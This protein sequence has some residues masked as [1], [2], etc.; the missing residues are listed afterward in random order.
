M[1]DVLFAVDESQNLS[2]AFV[3]LSYLQ[4]LLLA[5]NFTMY[6]M[7]LLEFNRNWKNRT[8]T[9]LLI[10]II[11]KQY[12]KEQPTKHDF[13]NFSKKKKVNDRKD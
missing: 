12:I 11:F 5:D 4:S 13:L 7:L 8:L 1:C 10:L 9:S 3:L 2:F 6:M